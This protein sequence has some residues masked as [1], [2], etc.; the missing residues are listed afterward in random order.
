MRALVS[1]IFFVACF[2]APSYA[3]DPLRLR[4]NFQ[5]LELHPYFQDAKQDGV[6]FS[7]QNGGSAELDLVLTRTRPLDLVIAF[8]PHWR[9]SDPLR[10]F[11]SDDREFSA[12]PGQGDAI[13]FSVPA[14]KVQS[15]YLPQLNAAAIVHLWS[16]DGL[17][18]YQARVQTFHAGLLLLLSGVL[19]LAI[20]M[21]VYRRSRRAVYAVIMG[22]SLMVLLASLWM[23]DMLPDDP[24]F[25]VWKANR[26]LVIQASF[27]LGVFMSV[28][29]HVNLVIRQIIH[30]N[31]WTRVIIVTDIFLITSLGLW[32]WQLIDP[33]YAGLISAQLGHIFMALTCTSVLLGAVFVP[34]RKRSLQPS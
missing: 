28:L 5:V 25:D 32:G 31:Y 6:I 13:S 12:A 3:A 11:S 30:R 18:T 20:A 4:E 15:F 29:A 2:F 9:Q 19:V 24:R 8:V 16:P 22:A 17:S 1:I 21:T 26:L 14:G 7:I 27:A 33:A 23:R 34:D 10:L